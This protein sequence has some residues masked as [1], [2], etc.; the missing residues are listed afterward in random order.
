VSLRIA[1]GRVLTTDGW[2]LGDLILEGG[3]VGSLLPSGAGNVAGATLQASGLMVAP[4]FI[5]LQICGGFGHDFTSEP[6]TLWQVGS[7]LPRHGV[8]AFLPTLVSCP[9]QTVDRALAVIQVGPPDGYAGATPLGLHCEGPML[10]ETRRGAHVARHL[11][12][13]SV[14]VIEGWSRTSG[15][16]MVTIAP[17]L[18]GAET[19][20]RELVDRSTIV[21]AGHSEATFEDSLKAF[22][23][24]VAAGTHLF[25]TMSGFHHREPGLAG[26]LLASPAVRTGLIADGVH[27]H[28]GAVSTAWRAKG[29]GGIALVTD[30]IA[31]MGTDQVEARLGDS[32]V[33]VAGPTAR[34]VE[35]RLAGS[36]LTLERA[37]GNLIQWTGCEPAQ[38]IAAAT[39]TPAAILDEGGRGVIAPGA[40]ADL[41][42]LTSEMRV[43]ATLVDGRVVFED[44]S[45]R[46]AVREAHP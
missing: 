21:S 45:A 36:V 31:A 34:S 42:L 13:P 39:S 37:V 43:V 30:A 4:G 38:A 23:Q 33:S 11:R 26:A 15:V 18:P 8:T 1:G 12:P 41:V 2:V 7:D 24:G 32:T 5:D 25:N 10:A 9:R 35:G 17:E 16:R 22:E 3:T 46:S 28:P 44:V 29:P 6:Q 27:V 19:V 14:E 40:R 20:I